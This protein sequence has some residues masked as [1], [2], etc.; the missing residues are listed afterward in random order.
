MV[1]RSDPAEFGTQG[2][3]AFEPPGF[4]GVLSG[5]PQTSQPCRQDRYGRSA[6]VSTLSVHCDRSRSAFRPGEKVRVVGGAFADHFGMFDS[7]GDGERVA[8]LLD[9][10]GRKVRVGM[11]INA[12][13]AA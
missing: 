6:A 10:L 12:I 4:R 7:M 1:R 5:L 11:N 13:E 9:I 8:V 3:R 2:R